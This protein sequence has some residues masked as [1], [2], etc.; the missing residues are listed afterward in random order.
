MFTELYRFD[1]KEPVRN[2]RSKL[3]SPL[4][5]FQTSELDVS[6]VFWFFVANT[7]CSSSLFSSASDDPWSCA[8]PPPAQ[9][10]WFPPFPAGLVTCWAARIS[11]EMAF[12][13]ATKTNSWSLASLYHANIPRATHVL[14][15]TSVRRTTQV[16]P[17]NSV[18]V[19]WL[20]LS[21]YG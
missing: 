18:H 11:R 14:R 7:D 10:P 5:I 21:T 3:K 17:S 15:S 8:S 12:L 13:S 20:F 16:F 9:V 4:K 6:T 2:Y 19:T 1:M